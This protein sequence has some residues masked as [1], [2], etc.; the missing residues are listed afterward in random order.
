M[1]KLS[2]S[3]SHWVVKHSLKKCMPWKVKIV[4][5]KMLVAGNYMKLQR[6]LIPSLGVVHLVFRQVHAV[7]A[8]F[9][10]LKAKYVSTEQVGPL[11][12]KM[13]K[14]WVELA[15]SWKWI[16]D[17]TGDNNDQCIFS[18]SFSFPLLFVAINCPC[19]Y[20]SFCLL[21]CCSC[22]CFVTPACDI[23]IVRFVQQKGLQ[24]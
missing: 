19:S 17:D 24:N 23:L 3:Y 8:C 15:G 12:V 22:S 1:W 16:H 11:K 10:H 7:H 20:C 9:T 2:S 5:K 4:L 18:Q 6:I 14:S 21:L 13:C